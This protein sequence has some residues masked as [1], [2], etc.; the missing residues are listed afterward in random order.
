[1]DFMSVTKKEKPGG[2]QPVAGE[3]RVRC[4]SC[5]KEFGVP[6]DRDEFFCV[7]CG[8]KH[9][10]KGQQP[11]Q[12]LGMKGEKKIISLD[13]LIGKPGT[14]SPPP[15]APVK[16]GMA[17]SLS[18]FISTTRGTVPPSRGMPPQQP[19]P[20]TDAI[21]A[22]PEP[23]LKR[24]SET[25]ERA[26]PPQDEYIEQ[27][28]CP[29]CT[30]IVAMDSKSCPACGV[31]FAEEEAASQEPEKAMAQKPLNI[32]DSCGRLVPDL[33]RL[34]PCKACGK[35]F[36]DNCPTPRVPPE[37]KSLDSKVVYKYKLKTQT[38]WTS[39]AVKFSE[40][41]NA[42]LC[43]K[44]Y[45]SEYDRAFLRLHSKVKS[46]EIDIR[47]DADVKILEEIFPERKEV[48]KTKKVIP[49]QDF[50]KWVAKG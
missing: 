27:C 21:P 50:L 49:A 7:H 13:A 8:K 31:Q 4:A 1:M 2:Q 36:C 11:A 28:Q 20:E 35:T 33:D 19:A 46:W 38:V 41:L 16:E 22:S 17:P 42:P 12:E 43:R 14:R 44:C 47:R 32:C 24:L 40:N 37:A 45:L 23:G 5:L 6:A 18:S 34:Y 48:V 25:D 29:V 15:I 30:T 3:R 10:Q 9:S 39:D 26:A